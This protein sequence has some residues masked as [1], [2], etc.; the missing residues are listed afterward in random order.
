MFT[1]KRTLNIVFDRITGKELV[2]IIVQAWGGNVWLK[3]LHIVSGRRDLFSKY[4]HFAFRFM[5]YN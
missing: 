1:Y 4:F 3:L 5:Y 2:K